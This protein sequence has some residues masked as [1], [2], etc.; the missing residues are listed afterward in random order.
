MC[1]LNEAVCR[2]VM[3]A[4]IGLARRILTSLPETWRPRVSIQ[5]LPLEHVIIG[6]PASYLPRLRALSLAVYTEVSRYIRPSLINANRTLTGLGPAA[7]KEHISRTMED[8]HAR[9]IYSPPYALAS[10]RDL[11]GQWDLPPS[12]PLDRSAVL[13]VAYCL[14]PD[15]Q[16]LLASCTDEQGH[17]LE[18][19]CIN[20]RLPQGLLFDLATRRFHTTPGNSASSHPA[21]A[22]GVGLGLDF[23]L[24]PGGIGS[25]RDFKKLLSSESSVLGREHADASRRLGLAI[26][27]RRLG[28]A[29]LW[30][31][32][33]SLIGQSSN[34]WRLVIGRLGRLGHG[35]LKGT[36][37]VAFF[38]NYLLSCTFIAIN[39]CFSKLY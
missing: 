19:I 11:W 37:F 30:D 9:R 31:F 28:L 8:W 35:E 32:I 12:E 2:L 14:S 21:G 7:E 10:S 20:L 23:G 39:F 29:R 4:L 13:F 26:S 1:D 3:Q 36:K 38:S 33:L 5:L 6:G 25:R 22:S 15:Q 24:G 17:M 16:W 27:P 18:Q 34:P